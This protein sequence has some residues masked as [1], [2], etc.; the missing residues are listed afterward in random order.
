MIS[1]FSNNEYGGKRDELVRDCHLMSPGNSWGLD[2]ALVDDFSLFIKLIVCE[3][4][5]SRPC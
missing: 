3:I 4:I 5:G 1:I 2:P